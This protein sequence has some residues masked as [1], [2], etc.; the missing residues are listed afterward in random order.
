MERLT[1][2]LDEYK[3]AVVDEARAEF[4]GYAARFGLIDLTGDRIEPGAFAK[5]IA[6]TRGKLN[7]FW[8]HPD[9]VF[10]SGDPIGLTKTLVEDHKGLLMNAY[11]ATDTTRGR[12]AYN[13]LKFAEQHDY[14]PGL[15]IGFKT[16]EWEI[17]KNVRVIKQIDLY[18]ASI[19]NFPANPRARVNEVKSVRDVETFLRD[20]GCSTSQAKQIISLC[21]ATT[22]KP[23]EAQRDVSGL[24]V[25]IACEQ[26]SL[27]AANILT[28]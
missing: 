6:D 13:W 21:K 15:S 14:S 27:R 24:K 17:E 22:D 9:P 23:E 16:V 26:M 7:V 4:T 2:A 5:S 1:F 8:G 3:A 18:E 20:V 11:L 25:T 12:D 10:G 19:V 28:R